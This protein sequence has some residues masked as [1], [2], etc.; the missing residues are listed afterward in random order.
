MANQV[1][2]KIIKEVHK[3]SYFSISV[4]STPDISHKDQLSFILRYVSENRK[5]VERFLCFIEN[6]GHKAEELMQF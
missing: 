1:T 6:S 5:P 3:A 4:T 2:D